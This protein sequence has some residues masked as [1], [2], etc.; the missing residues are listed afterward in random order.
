MTAEEVD[1][2]SSRT[3]NRVTRQ[4]PPSLWLRRAGQVPLR[5]HRR[6]G[7]GV[8]EWWGVTAGRAAGSDSL[9]ADGPAVCPYRAVWMSQ[10]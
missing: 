8:N 4:H 6:G 1:Y 10:T 7:R 5:P 3:Q 2:V 9:A